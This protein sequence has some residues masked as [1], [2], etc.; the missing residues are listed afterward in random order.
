MTA[1]RG[2]LR[3]RRPGRLIPALPA[4]A[5]G[6]GRRGEEEGGALEVRR[7][8]RAPPS[9]LRPPSGGPSSCQLSSS[10]ARGMPDLHPAGAGRELS[11]VQSSTREAVAD[12]GRS[13]ALPLLAAPEPLGRIRGW[14]AGAAATESG[15]GEGGGG[16]A[17]EESRG[18]LGSEPR[19]E[20]GAWGRPGGIMRG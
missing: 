3:S 2:Q 5:P 7:D 4:V 10:G 13:L 16:D 18:W 1:G 17:G 20:F 19:L 6:R 11:P 8:P 12:R 15:W 9:P 14:V